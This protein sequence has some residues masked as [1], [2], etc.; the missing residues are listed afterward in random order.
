MPLFTG[1]LRKLNSPKFKVASDPSGTAAS[2]RQRRGG[3]P[4]ASHRSNQVA[5]VAPLCIKVLRLV[6]AQLPKKSWP[7]GSGQGG[8]YDMRRMATRGWHLSLGA[9]GN[10]PKGMTILAKG[11]HYGEEKSRPSK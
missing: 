7:I 2:I 4:S 5:F 6:T 3:I 9:P 10:R 11:Q 8:V 1:V